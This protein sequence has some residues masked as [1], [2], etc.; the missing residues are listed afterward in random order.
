MALGFAKSDGER[1]WGTSSNAIIQS[2]KASF[3]AK[4][5]VLVAWLANVPQVLLSLTYFTINRV[6]TSV[7]FAKEWN[8]YATHRKGLRVTEPE[9]DQ[10]STY[11]LQLP[12]RW[13]FPL[14]AFSG[15]LHWLLSQSLFIVRRESMAR[16]GRVR[17][18]S[19]CACGYSAYSLAAFFAAFTVLM[20]WIL[21]LLRE[22]LPVKIPPAGNCSV[23][24]SAA[25]H[26]PSNDFD[27][28][29]K[30]VQWGVVREGTESNYGHCTFTSQEVTAP[31]KGCLYS[32][33]E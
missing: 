32:W 14:T 4:G 23:L 6:C 28:H 16:D 20:V 25:C 24:I 2:T 7:A 17:P 18:E 29:L 1:G 26:P 21:L 8:D 5:A 31:K 10:R 13:A 33:Q 30:P 19:T 11:F 22:K 9:G 27:G 12:Y 15:G 3:D